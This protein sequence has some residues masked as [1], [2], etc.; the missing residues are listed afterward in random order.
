M[1]L[2]YFRALTDSEFMTTYKY[3]E[4]EYT[5][6]YLGLSQVKAIIETFPYEKDKLKELAKI[7]ENKNAEEL[8]SFI[9]AMHSKGKLL[10]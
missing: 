6:K 1:M 7:V 10:L 5:R 8:I 3:S 2:E 4:S 9:K